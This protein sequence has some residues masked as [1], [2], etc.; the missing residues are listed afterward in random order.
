M[1]PAFKREE[2][3]DLNVKVRFSLIDTDSLSALLICLDSTSDRDKESDLFA[4]NTISA[5]SI[6]LSASD[7]RAPYLALDR[8]KQILSQ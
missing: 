4:L 3:K 7:L 1:A 2:V 6:T 8:Q 5:C